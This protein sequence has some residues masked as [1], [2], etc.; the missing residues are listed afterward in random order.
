[1]NNATA[2]GLQPAITA[3]DARSLIEQLQQLRKT[4]AAEL[5][6]QRYC[7]L[8]RQ[9]CKA[10]HC[11]VVR[12]L[13]DSESLEQLGRASELATWSPMQ[14]MPDGND[15]L[16]KAANL[17]YANAPAQASDGQ[18]W[19]VLVLA[20]QG[21]ADC[22]LILNIKTQERAQLNE[23]TLRALLCADFSNPATSSLT[24]TP[25]P[26]DLTDMLGLAAEIMQQHNFAAASLSLV[27]G[28]AAHW[29]LLHASLGWV[30]KGQL[31]VVAISHLDRFERNASQTQRIELALL[32]AVIQGSEVWWP[33]SDDTLHDTDALTSLAQDM[34]AERIALLPV[35]DAQGKTQAVLLLAF[36]PGEEPRS[37]NILQLAL[38]LIQPR[39]S[40]LRGQSLSL[41]R[42]TSQRMQS[43]A[44]RL[45]GPEHP[46][47][48]LS[49]ALL[50][51]LVL[52]LAFGSWHY[53]IDASAQLNTDATRLI[54]AQFD[55]RIDQVHA[56]AGDLVKVGSLLVTL[57]TRDLTQQ[58]NELSAEISKT[59]TEINK[60]R[61]EGQLA[62]TE[63]ANARLDQAL[64]KAERIDGYL[65]QASSTAPFEGVIVEGEKK[66]LVGAPV[67]KG[68]RIFRIAKVEGLYITLMVSEK[69]MRHIQPQARGEV[70]LLS[71]PSHN[72]PIRVSSV[73]PVAQ[74]KGQEGNQFMIKAE[75]LEAPQPWWRPGMTGL[76]RIDVGDKNVAWVLSHRVVDR[77]RLLLWW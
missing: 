61:A 8:M 36:G 48:K 70:S 52:Y 32:P 64:A 26:T 46:L 39:M 31:E 69:E 9:L 19:L 14:T 18:T 63:I 10:T 5:D 38:E 44:E 53:R 57:D 45:F 11:A 30:D 34:G 23:L 13:P 1:M 27:N 17:G 75:L 24:E 55:G 3:L 41:K 77:L 73:I 68:D 20:L 72:I 60:F 47:L 42:R 40:D 28:L 21:L 76:A 37:L 12:R 50:M 4:S 6:W 33:S 2:A 22:Y 67:K 16:A 62:E 58:R 65:T 35:P 74:V 59:N 56:T 43:A 29:K 54:S 49:G 51:L 25:P 66:D 7:V 71:H 15:L